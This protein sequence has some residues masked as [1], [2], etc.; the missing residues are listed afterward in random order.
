MMGLCMDGTAIAEGF[1]LEINRPVT[2]GGWSVE[3]VK[4]WI[5]FTE[6]QVWTDANLTDAEVYQHLM[7]LDMFRNEL[8]Y[9]FDR[10]CDHQTWRC[11]N[12]TRVGGY[13][14]PENRPNSP[15]AKC[16]LIINGQE[17]DRLNPNLVVTEVAVCSIAAT[18]V[19]EARCE[20]TRRLDSIR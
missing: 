20:A 16:R 13:V 5:D 14:I 10:S 4:A 1:K 19:H 7:V 2:S 8:H 18:L 6:A 9:R 15:R 17:L 11:P 12:R 3:D